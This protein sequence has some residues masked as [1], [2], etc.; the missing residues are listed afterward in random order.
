[1]KNHTFNDLSAGLTVLFGTAIF[2]FWWLVYPHALSYQE[3]YQLFLFD[4]AYFCQRISVAGGL[5]DYIGEFLV[6]FYYMPWLGA[7]ILSLVFV[8]IQ[9]L[10]YLSLLQAA[11]S[12]YHWAA[13][14]LS[15][16][17]SALLL[18]HVGDES[19]L[20]S[21]PV[22][23]LL[24][25]LAAWVV[26]G[27]FRRA[28][29]ATSSSDSARS[30]PGWLMVCVD[31]LLIPLF[32]WLVGPMV[33]LYAGLRV[34]VCWQFHG[35]QTLWRLAYV[36]L[37]QFLSY[38]FLLQQWPMMDVFLGLNYYR[39][40]MHAPAMQWILPLVIVIL[41]GVAPRLSTLLAPPKGKSTPSFLSCRLSPLYLGTL[42]LFILAINLGYD[43]DKYELIRQDYL[44]RNGCWDEIVER[45]AVYQVPTTFSSN[46]VN[47]ALAMKGQLAER[48][49][50]FYQS[51]EDALFMPRVRDLTS[52]L[53]T[54]EVFWQL[55]MVN[56]AQRYMF[57]VQ[58]SILNYRKSG[59]C[60]KRIA[61]CLI[62][63]GKYGVAAKYLDQLKKSLFY[64]SWAL[65]A[66][67]CLYH[68]DLVNKH[69]DWGRVRQLRYQDD[70]LYNYGEIEK[71]MGLLFTNN[72]RNKMALDYFMG[73]LLLKGK[74]QDFVHYMSWVQQYGGYPAMPAGYQDA[75]MCIQKR[76]DLPGS[77]YA[78][79]VKRMMGE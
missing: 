51:G 65:E 18:W 27:T 5:A 47:L 46:C 68:E 40:P 17:P 78:K 75:M 22:A 9:R 3:Q 52:N 36:P 16:I 14:P 37:L 67:A 1:M 64:R 34:V 43:R 7:M 77:S 13:L 76:G 31:L 8:A 6:Q 12:L 70:F 19:V 49:F 32:Y 28:D 4:N 60:T 79:Y 74:F 10:S 62:V 45:A 26:N 39:I 29:V 30:W 66:E 55:G 11:P 15:F 59:R 72:P 41:C 57:D 21:Y 50:D 61:E 35:W 38:V 63:N 23:M 58:E 2:L 53:P 33:W 48:M 24:M 71:M 42:L 69:P 54:A 25:L 56:S 44:V 73:E 20:L